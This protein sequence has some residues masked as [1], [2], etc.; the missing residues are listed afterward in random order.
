MKRRTIDPSRK[1]DLVIRTARKLFLQKG[2]HAVS[3]PDIVKESG[4]S[5]GAIYLHFGNKEKLAQAV[6]QQSS[7]E[8]IE[9]LLNHLTD[10]TDRTHCV[11]EVLA[12][13]AERVFEITEENPE[14]MDYL[15][16]IR[17]GYYPGILSFH[18]TV[19]FRRLEKIIN[20]GISSGEI[21]AGN[22]SLCAAAYCGVILQAVELRLNGQLQQPLPDIGEQIFENAWASIKAA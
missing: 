15:L 14:M 5:V 7:R 12:D 22:H 2:F 20:E 9:R 11:R 17:H 16:S 4:V 18:S 13:V 1:M 3:I 6:Y 8:F 21:R 19:I 10:K